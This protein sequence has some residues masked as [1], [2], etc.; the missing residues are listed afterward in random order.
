MRTVCALLAALITFSLQGQT[1]ARDL[2]IDSAEPSSDACVPRTI[3]PNDGVVHGELR[4]GECRTLSGRPVERFSFQGTV[5]EVMNIVV[6]SLDESLPDLT[7]VVFPDVPYLAIVPT[8]EGGMD[9]RYRNRMYWGNW[10]IVVQAQHMESH[11]RYMLQ[12]STEQTAEEGLCIA[13]HLHCNQSLSWTLTGSGCR[14]DPG[15]FSPMQFAYVYGM[16]NFMFFALAEGGTDFFAGIRLVDRERGVSVGNVP[17]LGSSR[18]ARVSYQ[19]EENKF[20]ELQVYS[21][22]IG[23]PGGDFRVTTNCT[24]PDCLV[25]LVVQQPR[26]VDV[27]RGASTRLAVAVKPD[28]A[29]SYSWTD[30][31]GLIVGTEPKLDLPAVL[32]EQSYRVT[33]ANEC[34]QTT[35]GPI[36]VRAVSSIRQRPSRP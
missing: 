17:D 33:V 5:G 4:W 10:T 19:F 16:R 9:I 2:R 7:L 12:L 18:E 20:Y 29:A 15:R 23:S 32:S 31:N 8:I 25:P 14:L 36:R 21:R 3:R 34:G 24:V 22:E 1:L 30:E 11:G 6:R 13:Q 26:T 28:R 35:S 27:L